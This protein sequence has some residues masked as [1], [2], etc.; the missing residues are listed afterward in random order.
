MTARGVSAERVAA[1]S[2]RPITDWTD[3]LVIEV[4]RYVIALLARANDQSEVELLRSALAQ[5]GITGQAAD[6]E[7][8]RESRSYVHLV[9]H[10]VTDL[11]REWDRRHPEYVLPE[12]DWRRAIAAGVRGMVQRRRG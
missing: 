8:E 3:E 2:A 11:T 10:A 1:A 4:T 12:E 9:V 5:Q 7:L 6:A